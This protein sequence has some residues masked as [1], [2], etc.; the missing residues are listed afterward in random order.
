[1]SFQQ[2]QLDRSFKQ[3]RGI[4]DIYAYRPTNG[5][6]FS[7]IGKSD[8]FLEA[9]FEE[10]ILNNAVVYVYAENQFGG[11]YISDGSSSAIFGAAL[12]PEQEAAVNSI[13]NADDDVLL[14]AQNGTLQPSPLSKISDTQVAGQTEILLRNKG[15]TLINLE[16]FTIAEAGQ[17]LL[18]T[19]KTTGRQNIFCGTGVDFSA[20]LGEKVS[21]NPYSLD[22]GIIE[23]FA[24][25]P[26]DETS[27]VGNYSFTTD[28][29]FNRVV[30]KIDFKC[31]NQVSGVRIIIRETDESGPVIYQSHNDVEWQSGQGLDIDVN[32][33][34]SI[35]LLDPEQGTPIL[36]ETTILL[37]ITIEKFENP[38]ELELIG[39]LVS[40]LAPGVFV[41][42]FVQEYFLETRSELVNAKIYTPVYKNSSSAELEINNL[43]TIAADVSSGSFVMSVDD[44][45]VNSFS[46]FDYAG[47]WSSSDSV[48]I[49]LASGDTYILTRSRR[50]YN[51]YKDEGGNW[52]WYY[53]NYRAG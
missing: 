52:Q 48:T 42:Y 26:L 10:Q 22:W 16:Q 20:V 37:N 50:K 19:D 25:Q 30:S 12:S 21:S 32:G 17:A 2:A 53:L 15:G 27:L 29:S 34:C 41:P 46:V 18:Q 49:N 24:A 36:V 35:D 11:Y 1:M 39:S 44:S 31:V 40:P 5:D 8:Y 47:S 6:T 33:E 45:V 38:N 7:D 51:F 13:I 9:R 4:F 28:V 14:L 3:T 43:E 23:Y